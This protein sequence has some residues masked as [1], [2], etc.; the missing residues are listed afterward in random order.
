MAQQ[1]SCP[2]PAGRTRVVG[3]P[4]LPRQQAPCSRSR[5]VSARW[6]ALQTRSLDSR[7]L[8]HRQHREQRTA[9]PCRQTKQPRKCSIRSSQ[10]RHRRLRM[11]QARCA[12]LAVQLRWPRRTAQA[13]R[14]RQLHPASRTSDSACRL[15]TKGGLSVSRSRKLRHCLHSQ[16]SAQVP[17]HSPGRAR[18]RCRSC[19]SCPR[20]IKSCWMLASPMTMTP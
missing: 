2:S 18:T 10:R 1:A 7:Q 8:P 6:T 19:R 17:R 12:R 13:V 20:P 11:L 15:S 5:S 16:R 14:T 3:V 4:T 9:T